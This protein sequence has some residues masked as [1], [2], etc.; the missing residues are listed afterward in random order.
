MTR[1][2]KNELCFN[3]V[4]SSDVLGAALVQVWEEPNGFYS[5][6]CSC[7]DSGVNYETLNTYNLPTLHE[8]LGV[9]GHTFTRLYNFITN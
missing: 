9:A 5:V 6:V 4:Q 1:I 8:A 2:L 3:V 7:F